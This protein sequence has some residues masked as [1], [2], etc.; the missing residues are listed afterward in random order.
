MLNIAPTFCDK[1]INESLLT[2][3]YY[4]DIC[5]QLK[6]SSLP[7]VLVD[8]AEYLHVE[9]TE[10]LYIEVMQI[11]QCANVGLCQHLLVCHQVPSKHAAVLSFGAVVNDGYGMCYNPQADDIHFSFSA[12]NS[13]A[14]TS[15]RRL[16]DSMHAALADGHDILLQTPAAKL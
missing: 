6:T 4:I 8:L 2:D 15:A 11:I 10:Y 3:S 9:V 14:D 13:C 7:K 12:W 1:L 16:A 5:I